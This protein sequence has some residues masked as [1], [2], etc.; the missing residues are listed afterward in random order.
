[1]DQFPKFKHANISNFTVY[2]YIYIYDYEVDTCSFVF[3]YFTRVTK[4][5]QEKYDMVQGILEKLSLK[6]SSSLSAADRRS[7][8]GKIQN[9]VLACRMSRLHWIPKP[10]KV[11][12]QDSQIFL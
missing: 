10:S 4:D 6:R 11:T 5:L 9:R 2:I 8:T 1:M 7:G 12:S 3:V